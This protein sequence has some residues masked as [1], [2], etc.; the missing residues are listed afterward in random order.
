MGRHQGTQEWLPIQ[1]EESEDEVLASNDEVPGVLIVRLR[2]HLHFANA[3]ALKE[4]LRGL[5]RYGAKKYHPSDRPSRDE[6]QVLVFHV[7]DLAQVDATALQILLETCLNYVRRGVPVYFAHVSTA[8]RQM[9]E[10][11]GIVQIIGQGKVARVKKSS[12]QLTFAPLP[13]DHLKD[14][15]DDSLRAAASDRR[16]IRSETAV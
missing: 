7:K 9:L 11:A 14:S 3:G 16:S 8:L 10:T 4:R 12:H 15:V 5:E 1:N 13:T 6:A 2:E